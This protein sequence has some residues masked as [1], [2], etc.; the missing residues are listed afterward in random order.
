MLLVKMRV[1]FLHKN[2]FVDLMYI[3]YNYTNR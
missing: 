3:R 2:D 1:C